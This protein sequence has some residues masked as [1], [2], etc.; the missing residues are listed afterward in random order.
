MSARR[1]LFVAGTDTGVGKTVVSAALLRALRGRGLRVAGMKPVASG[2]E[3]TPAGLRNEDALLLQA[4]C[5]RPWPYEVI[6]PLAFEPAI[7]P[8]IA[9][10]ESGR[11]ITAPPILA[12]LDQL[13]SDSDLVVVEGVGGFLVPL[14]EGL[15]G[16][17]LPG[18]L[19]LDVVLVVGL[20]LGCL[21]HALLSQEAIAQRGVRLVG[22]VGSLIDPAFERLTD[23]LD[24]LRRHLHAPCLGILPRLPVKRRIERAAQRLTLPELFPWDR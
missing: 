18:L 13:R 2:S 3:A 4:E 6:N 8:H 24:F 9:A 7:A 23:N 16:A 12:A 21:N 19:R 10:W 20:R 15:S 14:G 11:G 22:W 5:S 1:D 17:D